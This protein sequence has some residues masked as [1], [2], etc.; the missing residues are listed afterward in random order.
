MDMKLKYLCYDATLEYKEGHPTGAYRG[1]KIPAYLITLEKGDKK[2]QFVYWCWFG[3]RVVTEVEACKAI[4]EMILFALRGGK[5]FPNP[6][7][8]EA[9]K[10]YLNLVS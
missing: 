5:Q 9:Y 6:R 8:K 4:S 10:E 7:E 2:A 3:A 1:P